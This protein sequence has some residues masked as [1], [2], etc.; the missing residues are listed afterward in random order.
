MDEPQL[1]G[2]RRPNGSWLRTALFAIANG[3]VIFLVVALFSQDQWHRPHFWVT[4]TS[5]GL[6]IALMQFCF[7]RFLRWPKNS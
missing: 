6:T 4:I 7:T 5:L 2:L 1:D 3:V